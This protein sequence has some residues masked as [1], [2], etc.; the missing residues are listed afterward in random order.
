[1][2]DTELPPHLQEEATDTP[3]EPTTEAVA[4]DESMDTEEP[5]ATTE[6]EAPAEPLPEDPRPDTLYLEGVDELNTKGIKEY[7]DSYVRPNYSFSTRDEYAKVN[8]KL[9]WVNDS[10]INIVFISGE[11]APEGAQ[12]ALRLL[13]ANEVDVDSINPL[14]ERPA[15]PITKQDGDILN[16]TIR[17][18]KYADRKVKNARIYS[19]YYLLHGEPDRAERLPGAR[20][21]RRGRRNNRSYR[22]REV[23][24]VTGEREPD[25]PTEPSR[26]QERPRR[27]KRRRDRSDEAD[28]FP[29]F[30][31]RKQ[32]DRERERSPSRM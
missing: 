10:G 19:R 2:A 26:Y 9:E 15:Q 21:R 28:L 18:A 14:E 8:Y 24:L 11:D 27:D 25:I 23:D 5:A 32:E 22:E 29:D 3:V 31:K 12:E 4:A 30:L 13:S 17:Q 7:V 20:E 6:P 16:L 1:M